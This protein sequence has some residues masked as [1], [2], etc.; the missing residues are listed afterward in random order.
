[1]KDQPKCSSLL[2]PLVSYEENNVLLQALTEN[3]RLARKVS[4]RTNT[5]AYFFVFRVTKRKSFI[6]FF[7]VEKRGSKSSFWITHSNGAATFTL[8]VA[9]TINILQL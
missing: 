9:C 7:L 5:L 6:I 8:P 2:D 3:V 4:P 1:M